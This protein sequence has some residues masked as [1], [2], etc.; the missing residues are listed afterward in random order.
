MPYTSAQRKGHR[1]ELEVRDELKKRGCQVIKAGGS[2]GPFDLIAWN[3][4]CMLFVQVKC[5]GWPGP[6]ER[7][8]MTE[9]PIPK[10]GQI[11]AARKNDYSRKIEWREIT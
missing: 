7:A 6:E 9:H 10:N 4:M 3:A 11:W 1:A 5:N 8:R 2:K